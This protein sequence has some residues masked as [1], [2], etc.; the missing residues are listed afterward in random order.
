MTPVNFELVSV[1]AILSP[2]DSSGPGFGDSI[3]LKKLLW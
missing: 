1:T 3:V 2:L